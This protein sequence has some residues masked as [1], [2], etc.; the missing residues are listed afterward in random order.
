MKSRS[1]PPVSGVYAALVTPRKG[2]C[3]E[4]D[5]ARLLDYIERVE[6][7]GV[8][9][10]VLFG[11][12]GEFV[13]FDATERMRVTGFAIKRSRTPLL[14]NVSHSDFAGVVALAE[15]A[16]QAGAA[17][18][19]VMPPY[20]YGYDG[21]AIEAFYNAIAGLF[22]DQIPIFLYN[23]PQHTNPIPVDVAVRLLA[24]GR[25][26]GIKDSGGDWQM[27]ESLSALR[28]DRE[29]RLLLGSE[30]IYK[31][32]RQEGADGAVSGVAAALPELVTGLE[33]AVTGDQP[34]LADQ[35]ENHILEYLTWL[36]KF[37]ATFLIRQTAALRGWIT[38]APGLP[39]SEAQQS[40]LA[41][42]REWFP[43]WFAGIP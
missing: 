33:K 20:F 39:L 37:P 18:I 32:A 42:F 8:S 23:L 15:N 22:A 29:F 26:A 31:R 38:A 30:R 10:L 36:E 13:H 6:N 5:A 24:S 4:A 14:V 1:A 35:L 21:A 2:A 25:F 3:C 12:T 34:E 11:S 43:G 17:G 16:I 27:F 19:F 40:D 9:G 28:R 41:S 7:G